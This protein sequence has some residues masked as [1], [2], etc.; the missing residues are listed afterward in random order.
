[1][2]DLAV[3][4]RLYVYDAF[5]TKTSSHQ[6]AFGQSSNRACAIRYYWLHVRIIAV[7]ISGYS[8]GILFLTPRGL[9]CP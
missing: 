7:P 4:K 2:C 5:E 9:K 6:D 8:V 3:G 1:M